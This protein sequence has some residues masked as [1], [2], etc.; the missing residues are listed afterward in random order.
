M[1]TT[2]QHPSASQWV[3]FFMRLPLRL[4]VAAISLIAFAAMIALALF[5][6]A[7][8]RYVPSTTKGSPDSEHAQSA[9][10]QCSHARFTPCFAA[11]DG[12]ACRNEVG[13]PIARLMANGNYSVIDAVVEN[14]ERCLLTI[15]VQGTLDGNSY[16]KTG[17][18][19]AWR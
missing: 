5:L 6:A 17:R 11:E 12:K 13:S 4:K 15:R 1:N 2:D 19:W 10:E 8:G 3:A 7:T 18:V 16:S 14:P 9:R